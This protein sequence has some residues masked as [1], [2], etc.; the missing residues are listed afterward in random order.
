[1]AWRTIWRLKNLKDIQKGDLIF[2]Y[3]TGDEK[4][5]VGVAA[6]SAAPMR[7]RAR[8]IPSYLS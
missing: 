6:L 3:H 1:M 8:K 7:I 2:I 5:A 4:Q